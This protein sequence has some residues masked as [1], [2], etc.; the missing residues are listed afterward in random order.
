MAFAARQ[1]GPHDKLSERLG[2]QYQENRQGLGVANAFAVVELFVSAKG[3]WTMTST[4][5]DGMTCV[6]ATGEGWQQQPQTVAG[7]ES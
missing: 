7:L 3:T 1:C 4:T 6:I 5:T 2:Q